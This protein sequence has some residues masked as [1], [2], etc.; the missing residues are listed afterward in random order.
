[1]IA[2]NAL[3]HHITS[4]PSHHIHHITSH[5]ITS[6]HITSH[7]I[8]SHHITSHAARRDNATP[9]HNTQSQVKGAGKPHK[10]G[11]RPPAT[12]KLPKTAF[13]PKIQRAFDVPKGTVPRQVQLDRSRRRFNAE[14]VGDVLFESHRL[15]GAA[16]LPGGR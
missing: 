1:M 4:H 5:H 2:A 6:H 16:L 11:P 3:T 15:H 12:S 14:A 10:A 7:H 9:R 13:E 8:T